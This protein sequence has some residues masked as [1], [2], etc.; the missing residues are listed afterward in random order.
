MR[1]THLMTRE[2]IHCVGRPWN[3]T[4]ARSSVGMAIQAESEPND[5][6]A[7]AALGREDAALIVMPDGDL[8]IACGAGQDSS[9]PHLQQFELIVVMGYI[10]PLFLHVIS[11]VDRGGCSRRLPWN[12]DARL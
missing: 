9:G 1:G 5:W 3:A 2:G 12:H 10:R 11:C 4:R 8:V 7:I 6:V